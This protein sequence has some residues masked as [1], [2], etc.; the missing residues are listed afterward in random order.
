MD[1]H[2]GFGDAAIAGNLFAEASLAP[3][4]TGMENRETRKPRAA[5]PVPRAGAGS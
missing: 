1:L 5:S 2:R 4:E 3:T